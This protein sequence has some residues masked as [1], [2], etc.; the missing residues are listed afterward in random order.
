M[1]L[2]SNWKMTIF[3]VHGKPMKL[4]RK[5][6]AVVHVCWSIIY[7]VYSGNKRYY[8]KLYGKSKSKSEHLQNRETRTDPVESKLTEPSQSSASIQI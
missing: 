4:F 1:T 8:T 5:H 7:I 3:Y 2:E 6:F